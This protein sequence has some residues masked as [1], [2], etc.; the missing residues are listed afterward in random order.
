MER[1][2]MVLSGSGGDSALEG[3][4]LERQAGNLQGSF[5]P[6][7]PP[8]P[9]PHAPSTCL[10]CCFWA[11]AGSVAAARGHAILFWEQDTCLCEET[12]AFP[13]ASPV[14]CA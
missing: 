9:P 10:Q 6:P 3:C 11:G 2:G 12:S 5:P 1:E 13:A 7:P 4:G 14:T 8:P